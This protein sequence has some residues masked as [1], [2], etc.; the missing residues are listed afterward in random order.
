MG[1]KPLMDLRL[2]PALKRRPLS[3]AQ[4]FALDFLGL[5]TAVLVVNGLI[6]MALTYREARLQAVCVQQEKAIA[7]AERVVQFVSEIEQHLGS[8]TGP[9]GRVSP[10]RPGAAA[11]RLY[12]S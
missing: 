8:S 3:L 11:L 12:L 2:G 5:V 4:N 10:R 7:A 6:D 9:R 1:L